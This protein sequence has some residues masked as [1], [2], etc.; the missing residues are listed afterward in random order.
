MTLFRAFV[1]A[2]AALLGPG[3]AHAQSPIVDRLDLTFGVYTSDKAT[4][5]YR[6][7]TPVLEHLQER[8]EKQLHRSVDTELRI[9]KTYNE[10]LEAFVAG[11]VDFVRFGPASYVLARARDPKIE[12][13]AMELKGGRKSFKGM[14][15]VRRDSPIQELADLRGRSFAFGDRN[16]TIGRYLAQGKLL[17]AKIRA[18]DLSYHAF[19]G[20]HDRVFRAVQYGDYDAGS[21]KENTYTKLNKK[22]QLRV[23]VKFDNVT[24]PWIARSGLNPSVTAALRSALLGA[25]DK[26]ALASLKVDGFVRATDEDFAP[27][28]DSM[29]R[30]ETFARKTA[31]PSK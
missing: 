20:R 23:L 14:I 9:Y 4:T 21:V 15:I 13:L 28:R 3:L 19:L 2:L 5:M 30:A 1:G 10:A 31:R 26:K 22:N 8:L 12:L 7:F 27:I 17:A 6:K 18:Q 25:N 24:K 29:K 11:K 16:S